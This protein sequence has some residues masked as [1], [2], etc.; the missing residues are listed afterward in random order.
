VL[1]VV[2]QSM[3]KNATRPGPAAADA[4]SATGCIPRPH[5]W[6]TTWLSEFIIV[7]LG[8]DTQPTTLT[9]RHPAPGPQQSDR[10]RSDLVHYSQGGPFGGMLG[11]T[12]RTL[13]QQQRSAP[14][15]RSVGSRPCAAAA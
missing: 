1:S 10:G 12:G 15:S 2:P 4:I 5:R 6:H 8:Q 11:G 7:P 14:L 13:A 3:Q 9:G